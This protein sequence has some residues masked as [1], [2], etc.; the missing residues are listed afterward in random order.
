MGAIKTCWR[1]KGTGYKNGAPCDMCRGIGTYRRPSQAQ[2]NATIDFLKL[3]KKEVPC[4]HCGGKGVQRIYP[5][6]GEN[7]PYGHSRPCGFCNGTGNKVDT[8]GNE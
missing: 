5:D 6:T 1:C 4:F 3:N 2:I 7:F 8:R